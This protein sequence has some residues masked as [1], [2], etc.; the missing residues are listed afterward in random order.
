MILSSF[1]AV[2]RPLVYQFFANILW[3]VIGRDYILLRD[4]ISRV[5]RHTAWVLLSPLAWIYRHG[6]TSSATLDDDARIYEPCVLPA[7]T[8]HV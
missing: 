4:K 8:K 2:Q 6:S 3:L 1:A 5:T 7:L